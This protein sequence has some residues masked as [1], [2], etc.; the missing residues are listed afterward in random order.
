[1]IF[2]ART[3]DMRERRRGGQARTMWRG[4]C[5]RRRCEGH[6]QRELFSANP[7][8]RHVIADP[9]AMQSVDQAEKID[10]TD[11]RVGKTPFCTDALRG[12]KYIFV[13]EW[14]P[15][16]FARIKV[17]P[18]KP[19][20]GTPASCACSGRRPPLIKEV[21]GQVEISPRSGPC[22]CRSRS[23]TTAINDRHFLSPSS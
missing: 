1:M 7:P 22:P 15:Y 14:G 12:L 8:G 23:Q 6:L 9:I 19:C 20:S 17:V 18:E 16:D 13:D 11:L 2:R 10:L 5:A 4:T 3:L 21:R